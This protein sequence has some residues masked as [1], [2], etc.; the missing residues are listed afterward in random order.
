MKIAAHMPFRTLIETDDYDMTWFTHIIWF[1]TASRW[2]CSYKEQLFTGSDAVPTTMAV[3]NLSAL[4]SRRNIYF[5]LVS[6]QSSDYNPRQ[7][8][9][10]EFQV[11][12]NP[13][14][15]TMLLFLKKKLLKMTLLGILDPNNIFLFKTQHCNGGRGSW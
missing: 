5:C 10:Q 13:P 6:G 12:K 15:L 7:N 14:P 4:S 11:L 2:W 3:G 8:I 1:L 9:W